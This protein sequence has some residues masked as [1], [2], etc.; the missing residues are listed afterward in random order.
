VSDFDIEVRGLEGTIRQFS[1]GNLLNRPLRRFFERA[2]I[3]VQGR[4]R[5]NAPSDRGQLRSSISYEIDRGSPPLFA[6]VGVI[7]GGAAGRLG[8]AAAA[9][10][11]GTGLLSDGPGGKGGGH[12]PPS[13]EL[14]AWATRH[15][16]ANGFLVARAI[17]RRGGLKPRRYLRGALEAST[18]EINRF[19][20]DIRADLE[21]ELAG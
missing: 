13:S 9:M 7:G 18:G 20:Q 19:A 6:K 17:A 16:I 3:L 2:A 10:E 14:D 21:K 4:A 11:Y 15:G 1:G 8:T 12:F 5:M